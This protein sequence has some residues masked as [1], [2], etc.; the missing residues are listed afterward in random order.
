VFI[1][2]LF[3]WHYSSFHQLVI[4]EIVIRQQTTKPPI[5][6]RPLGLDRRHQSDY[7]PIL[8]YQGGLK[9]ARG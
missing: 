5:L 8:F 4:G 6:R 9:T 2:I 3:A 1:Q 7:A